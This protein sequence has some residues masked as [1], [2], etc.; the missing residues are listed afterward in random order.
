MST[1]VKA[2]YLEEASNVALDIKTKLGE[3][4][5]QHQAS[6]QPEHHDHWQ[7]PKPKPDVVV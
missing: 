7:H 5:L 3:L 2:R 4:A 1:S 6:A